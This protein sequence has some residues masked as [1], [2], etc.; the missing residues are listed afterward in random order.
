MLPPW[1]HALAMNSTT[2]LCRPKNRRMPDRN[3]TTKPIERLEVGDRVWCRDLR[4]GRLT[5]ACVVRLFRRPAQHVLSLCVRDVAGVEARIE[6]TLEHPYWVERAGWVAARNLR[7]GHLIRSLHGDRPLRVVSATPTG[8]RRDVFNVE[9]EGLHNYHVGAMGALVHNHS[10]SP[11]LSA[12]ESALKFTNRAANDM[13]RLLAVGIHMHGTTLPDGTFFNPPGNWVQGV[14]SAAKMVGYSCLKNPAV[15]ENLLKLTAEYS[16]YHDRHGALLYA[17][18]PKA[19]H[20]L[21][22][23]LERIFRETEGVHGS[24]SAMYE[25]LAYATPLHEAAE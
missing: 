5:S 24:L 8:E 19:L 23:I 20:G 10:A 25:H 13:R 3:A 16:D 7:A 4:S 9:V 1:S 15:V 14:Q 22:G 6:S 17:G 21:H 18:D 2:R 11:E 12:V